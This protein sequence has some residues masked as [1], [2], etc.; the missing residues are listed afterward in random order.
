[1]RT[2]SMP[3][4]A[5]TSSSVTVAIL[6]GAGDIGRDYISSTTYTG[7]MLSGDDSDAEDDIDR[8]FSTDPDHGGIDTIMT[9]DGDDIIIGGE[10]GEEISELIS[11]GVTTAY[12]VAPATKSMEWKAISSTPARATIWYL[13]ITAR[14][15]QQNRIH[16][17]LVTIP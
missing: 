12:T 16:L 14:S 5:I 3:P 15:L 4:M 6:I 2:Q 7:G 11:N 1:M 9:G 8:I 17:D 13:G 10:D